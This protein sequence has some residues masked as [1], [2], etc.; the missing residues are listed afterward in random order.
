MREPITYKPHANGYDEITSG[1]VRYGMGQDHIK[2]KV[3]DEE[4]DLR[5]YSSE[6]E[7][8]EGFHQIPT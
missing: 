2:R 5:F 4:Y 3:R 7:M 1:M 8:H 6:A